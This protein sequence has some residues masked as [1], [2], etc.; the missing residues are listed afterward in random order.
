MTITKGRPVAGP[1]LPAADQPAAQADGRTLCTT[2]DQLLS[3]AVR[4]PTTGV[5][6]V[7][8]AGELDAFTAPLL[9]T[10][11]REL[12][13]AA[14]TH[15]ILILDLQPVRFLGCAGLVCL[16]EAREHALQTTGSQLH[17]AGL[18][19]RAV[20][21]LLQVTE[22]LEL[23]DTYPTLTHALTALAD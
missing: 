23:F 22:L 17:L 13:T 7:T 4:R 16:L 21:R 10:R 15:L 5:C 2:A 12:L 20:A 1:G 8:V 18:V 11:L 9:A 19:T 14:P 6:V 3:L